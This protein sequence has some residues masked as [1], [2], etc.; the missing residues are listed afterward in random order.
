MGLRL[1]RGQSGEIGGNKGTDLK[2]EDVGRIDEIIGVEDSDRYSAMI[3]FGRAVPDE[4][5][6]AAFF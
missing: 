4:H 6:M 2:V 1:P 5:D 3:N